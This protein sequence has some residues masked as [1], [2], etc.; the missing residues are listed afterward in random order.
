MKYL[1]KIGLLLVVMAL[2]FTVTGCDKD[3]D[4]SL[5]SIMEKL[6]S[7]IPE[8]N[9]PMALHNIK[10]FDNEDDVDSTN[11]DQGFIK[12]FIGTDEIKFEE[13]I[14]SE[15]MTGSVAHS[16]VLLKVKN[17]TDIEKAKS[18]IKENVDPRK[19]ICVGVEKDEVVIKNKGNL[20]AVIIV[21][22]K[23]N[24]DNISKNFDNL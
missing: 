5:E 15:S 6:Y 3:V 2:L 9:L 17:G 12:Y 19:W 7:N 20:I 24:R 8:E 14:A 21:Q 22:N 10:L 18:T 1:K 11:M 23:E 4:G 13:A 16:V